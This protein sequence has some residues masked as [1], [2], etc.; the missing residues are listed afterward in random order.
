MTDLIDARFLQSPKELA[1]N[2][3]DE[4]PKELAL[5]R[6]DD[7]LGPL[8]TLKL[9]RARHTKDV[10]KQIITVRAE[11]IICVSVGEGL[12]FVVPSRFSE[13]AEQIRK[14]AYILEYEDNWDDEGSIAYSKKT[15]SAAIN[16]AIEYSKAIW[17]EK[18]VLIHAPNI[19]PGPE[20]SIDLL[21]DKQNYRLLLNI[22]PYPEQTASFY[23]D[24]R[25]PVPHIKG[26]FNLSDEPDLAI[27]LL[28]LK[29]KR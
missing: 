21:W 18:F 26:D 11:P 13:L 1:L 4:S 24:N 9:K 28:L 22:H 19:L 27:M 20:G 14:S 3:N 2:R 10:C 25:T 6:N 7:W 12:D 8:G 16:F 29:A 5:N 23:G 17:E 15:F